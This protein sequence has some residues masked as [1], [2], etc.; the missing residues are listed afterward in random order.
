M[1][2]VSIPTEF[3]DMPA[4]LSRPPGAGPCPGVVVIHDAAG[5]TQDL[6]NRRIGSRPRASSP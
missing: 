1:V 2:N 3:G 4:Y 6:V 5:M